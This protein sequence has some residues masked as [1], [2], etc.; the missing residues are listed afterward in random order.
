MIVV[1]GVASGSYTITE[2]T[3]PAG[4]NKLT[5]PVTVEAVKTGETNTH[6]IV[7]LDKD[8]N[9]TNT[10]TD[11]KTEVKV[12]IEKI[13]AKPVVVVNKAGTELPST[14]GMGTTVFYVLGFALVMGAVVLL[15]TKKRMSDAN[16]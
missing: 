4:Y 14:G 10:E 2:D 6:T 16:G 7:Y 12:D 8:G 13:A 1:K 15:V 9:I 5:T 11:E 3:A